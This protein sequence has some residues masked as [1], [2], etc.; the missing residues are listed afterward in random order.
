[1]SEY[2]TWI[3]YFLLFFLKFLSSGKWVMTSQ[4]N[5]I[6]FYDVI[7]RNSVFDLGFVTRE[8]QISPFL[9]LT[10]AATVGVLWKKT[11]LEIS[12]NTQENTCARVSFLIKLQASWEFCDISK[13]TF[14]TEH[15]WTT[16][17]D[18]TLWF[19]IGRQMTAL[20]RLRKTYNQGAEF[21]RF[22]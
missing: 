7:T 19:Q 8:F 2:V 3:F 10:E 13:N 4:I 12:Q 16:A 21:I 14:F 15:L 18:L 1:M 22:K 17:S 5:F 9:H 6:R 11:F 20:F